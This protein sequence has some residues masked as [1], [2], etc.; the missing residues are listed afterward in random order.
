MHAT[1]PRLTLIGRYTNILLG[2]RTKLHYPPGEA[3]EG[4]EQP[5]NE[6]LERTAKGYTE[7]N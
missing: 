2:Y 6:P 4:D 3:P 1:D 5:E 7:K